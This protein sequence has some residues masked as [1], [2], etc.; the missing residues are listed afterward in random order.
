MA[1]L[2]K[3][4]DLFIVNRDGVDYSVK[5]E[6][7]IGANQEKL[8]DYE[9]LPCVL[10]PDPEPDDSDDSMP[11][12]NIPPGAV[13]L[14]LINIKGTVTLYEYAF[15]RAWDMDG[16]RLMKREFNEGE[17][18]VIN[19]AS[20]T[21]FVES[22]GNWDFGEL[23][24]TSKA[25]SFYGMFMRCRE[26]NTESIVTMFN[27][28]LCTNTREMFVGCEK[29]DQDLSGWCVPLHEGGVKAKQMFFETPME[30]KTDQHPVWG[31][32]PGGQNS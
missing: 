10:R 23:T 28:R 19:G 7:V 16:N 29:F 26:F 14:H 4:D 1:D 3:P 27:M 22:G 5:A 2:I 18:V 9:E 24:D 8:C 20:D 31:T 32:C 11:W 25:T 30:N 6:E 21:M 15:C 12:D 17:E 13:R